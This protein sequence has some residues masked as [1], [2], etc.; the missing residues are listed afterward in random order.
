MWYI[1]RVKYYSG[2]KWQEI[3]TYATTWMNL[4]DVVSEVNQTQKGK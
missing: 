4:E 2:F 1:Y 3:L